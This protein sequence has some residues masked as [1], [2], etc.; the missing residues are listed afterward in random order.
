VTGGQILARLRNPELD[1]E[2]EAAAAALTEAEVLRN[3]ALL[4]A[5]ADVAALS[6]R[7]EAAADRLRDLQARRADLVVRA[8]HDGVWSASGLHERL[9]NWVPRGQPLGELVGPTALRF[10]AAVS[11][12]QADQLFRQDLS[13]AELRLGGQAGQVLVP[14]RLL[15][16]PY[17]RDRLIS[18]A[19][20]WQ[21]GGTVPVRPDDPQGLSTVDTYYE[22]QANFSTSGLD[23]V[24]LHGMTGWVRVPLPPAT[25]WEQAGRA[26]RQLLQKRYSL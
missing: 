4:S 12:E 9:G 6:Q 21:S 25:L 2:I 17:E 11:Q 20:G 8:R 26:L 13:A 3:Q 23:V 7:I 15:L 19:L 1:W 24:A 18:Q 14:E 10:S 5:P 16:V 22:L